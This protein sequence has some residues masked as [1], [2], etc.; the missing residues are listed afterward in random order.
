MGHLNSTG[1]THIKRCS[2]C[3]QVFIQKDNSNIYLGHINIARVLLL[4]S[5]LW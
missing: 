5:K 1:I 2:L 3:N 4:I